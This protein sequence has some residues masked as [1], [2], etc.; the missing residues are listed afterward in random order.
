MIGLPP[1]DIVVLAVGT[2]VLAARSAARQTNKADSRD[3]LAASRS[4][5]EYG[6]Y[7]NDHR[8]KAQS[9]HHCGE[10][11]ILL[12]D[13]ASLKRREHHETHSRR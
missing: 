10:Q 8:Q 11:A 7:D 13:T 9:N 12:H 2:L 4:T 5:P 6:C 1:F 3:D